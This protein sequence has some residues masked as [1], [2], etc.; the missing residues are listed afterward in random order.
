LNVVL[1][2]LTVIYVASGLSQT[3]SVSNTFGSWLHA[4]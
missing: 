4:V 3:R 1:L 2:V